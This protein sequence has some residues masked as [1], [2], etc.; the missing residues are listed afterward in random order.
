MP[1][2][3]RDQAAQTSPFSIADLDAMIADG[4]LSSETAPDGTVLVDRVA[5]TQQA[6]LKETQLQNGSLTREI[7]ALRL[8]LA[9]PQDRAVP[10]LALFVAAIG[11][12]IAIVQIMN[13]ID[14][15]R[16]NNDYKMQS[17]YTDFFRAVIDAPSDKMQSYAGL[18]DAKF[19]NIY[20]LYR[21]GG[22]SAESWR[23]IATQACPKFRKEGFALSGVK[24]PAVEKIC[25][26][27]KIQ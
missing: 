24:L 19:S 2:I 6:V 25:E 7:D 26:Q 21:H 17:D 16:T 22:I 14:F 3:S 12:G 27:N 18:Y 13:A 11:A 20:D 10:W 4:R 9:R 15:Y 5:V 8:A 1:G 23:A